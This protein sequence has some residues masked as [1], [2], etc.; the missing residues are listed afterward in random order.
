MHGFITICTDH[1]SLRHQ[2]MRVASRVIS[3]L[4]SFDTGH[5]AF[6]MLENFSNVAWSAPGILAFSVRWTAVMA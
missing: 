2:E 4:S 1:S 5:P 6:A 3:A